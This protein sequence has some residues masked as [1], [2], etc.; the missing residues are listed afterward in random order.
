MSF[1]LTLNST[2]V[3]NTNTNT[4]FKYN[5][6]NG[7]FTCRDYEMCISSITL[8]YSFFNGSPK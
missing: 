4:T 2:N 1:I 5:F 7:G 8:P 6:I 3:S